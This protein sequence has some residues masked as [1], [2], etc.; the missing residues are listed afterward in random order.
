LNTKGNT[1]LP[2]Y[3]SL[4]YNTLNRQIRVDICPGNPAFSPKV[5]LWL[6]F[7]RFIKGS[8]PESYKL[9][10][11]RLVSDRRTAGCAKS[12]FG[13][14]TRLV[15]EGIS[16][17]K[18][19]ILMFNKYPSAKQVTQTF[20]AHLAMTISSLKGWMIRFVSY[21]TAKT[22]TF[23][24]TSSLIH[25]SIPPLKLS[26]VYTLPKRDVIYESK[27]VGV[28]FNPTKIWEWFFS[29]LN[30]TIAWN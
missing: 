4:E 29:H 30:D 8:D 20:L 10:A 5:G 18:T 28:F 17:C 2:L 6:E 25:L 12:T 7:G 9:Y 24:F 23:N 11:N 21:G 19:E 27:I 22:A 3:S 1:D 15:P 13:D 26:R 16:R 14:L